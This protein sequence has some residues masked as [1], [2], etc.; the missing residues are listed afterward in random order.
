MLF[1]VTELCNRLLEASHDP[2]EVIREM[3]AGPLG[4]VIGRQ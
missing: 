2:T 4:G 1:R 3:R